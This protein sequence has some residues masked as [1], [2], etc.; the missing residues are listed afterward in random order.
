[1]KRLLSL[2]VVLAACAGLLTG[3]EWFDEPNYNTEIPEGMIYY[4]P[5]NLSFYFEDADGN[6]LVD[7]DNPETYPVVYPGKVTPSFVRD[8]TSK[9]T[10]LIEEGIPYSLYAN[11]HNWLFNDM[12]MRRV[13]F[14]THVWG[15]T[16]EPEYTSYVY[17]GGGMD[18]L[19]VSFKYITANDPD[20]HIDGG[21]WA[22]EVQSVKYNTVEV[23]N[24]NKEGK[25]YVRKPSPDETAVRISQAG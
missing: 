21:G 9:V 4:T 5:V 16:V 1:M 14:G 13:C 12:E 8:L 22:V 3:C 18:S 24:G 7:L 17:V 15:R 23:L 11:D 2:T 19:T 20:V 6:D 10:A 25:V